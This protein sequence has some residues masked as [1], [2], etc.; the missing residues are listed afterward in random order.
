[1][2]MNMARSFLT[3]ENIYLQPMDNSFFDPKYLEWVNDD[4][5]IDNMVTLNF[6]ATEEALR[7]YIL[8]NTSKENIA[9]FAIRWKENNEFIGTVKL[10]PID[11][12]HRKAFYGRLIGDKNY[13][14]KG[15][16]TEVAKLILSYAFNRLNLHWI[17]ATMGVENIMSIKSNEKAG[18][19]KIAVIPNQLWFKGKYVDNIIMGITSEEYFKSKNSS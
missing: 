15:V 5:I 6:P 13:R 3:G 12:I 8:E 18:L 17:G 11:W 9:F 2:D 19:K 14:G 4:E 7:N 1:M 10:G 16:G